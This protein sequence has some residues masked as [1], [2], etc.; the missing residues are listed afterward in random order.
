MAVEVNG[1]RKQAG[2]I[3]RTRDCKEEPEDLNR[4][5]QQQA[6]TEEKEKMMQWLKEGSETEEGGDY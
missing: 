2:R 6:K 1:A 3:E 5:M 4:E